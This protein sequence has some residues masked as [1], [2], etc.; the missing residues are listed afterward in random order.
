M[1][2]HLSAFVSDLYAD[3][4]AHDE[5]QPDRLQKRRNLEPATA[6][7]LSLVVRIAAARNVVEVGTANGYSTIWLADA[8]ADTGG[9]VVS[10]DTAANDHA[11]ASLARADAI[12]AGLGKRVDLRRP[13]V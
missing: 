13:D 5:R 4:V 6:E 2:Q 11:R 10:I 9:H 8:V 7:L 1:N 12:Q 3:G